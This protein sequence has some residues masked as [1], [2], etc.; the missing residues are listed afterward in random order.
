[1]SSSSQMPFGIKVNFEKTLE[2]PIMAAELRPDFFYNFQI[3]KT[4]LR[5]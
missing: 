5:S 4:K 3:K 1:M 2:L